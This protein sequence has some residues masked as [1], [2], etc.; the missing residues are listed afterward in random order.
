MGGASTIDIACGG[1]AGGTRVIPGPDYRLGPSD[2]LDV[3]IAGRLEVS[4][5]QLVV[6]PEGVINIPPIGAI[7]VQG[8]TV[9]EAQRAISERARAV[10]RFVDVSISVANARCVELPI[11]GEVEHPA[12]YQ[13]SGVRRVQ[14]AIVLAGGV[15]PRGSVRHVRV[16]RNGV[17]RS[18]DLLRF[19]LLGDLSQNPTVEEGMRVYVPPRGP[20]VTLEGSVRRPGDYEIGPDDSLRDLLLVTGGLAQNA[21]PSEARLTR[22]DAN[23]LRETVPLDLRTAVT[24]P[25]DVRLRAGDRIF[26]PTLGTLQGVVEVRGA[27]VGNADSSKTTT[28]GKATI[29][30]R[31]ELAR[32]DRVKDIL[33][34][35]G[36]PAAYADLRMAVVDRQGVEGP[37]ETIP[38]DLHRLLVDKDESQNIVLENGDVFQLPIVDDKV[39]V[40]GEVRAPGPQDYRPD[41]TL[42]EYVALAG[43]PT[44]RGRFQKALVT[45]RDGRTFNI[46]QAPPLEPGAVVTIPEV[47]VRWWQDYVTISNAITGLITTYTG[48]YLLYGGTLPVQRA[49]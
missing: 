17:T 21:A 3:Q 4:R 30:Q 18:L 28:A 45:Y 15:S 39:Y 22:D 25:A 6:D 11:A 35:A 46:A 16:T 10:Y 24:P 20:F 43:G 27:F 29:V 37:R 34:R 47:S 2:Q 32:G 19:E 1:T 36:G 8:R 13:V 23:G 26:V 33:V 31:F 40:L 14:E 9:L 7:P 42:R 12:V 49:D 41:L 5:Q 44:V 48:L 38:I